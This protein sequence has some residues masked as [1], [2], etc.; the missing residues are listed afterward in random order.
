MSYPE[1][2][3]LCNTNGSPHSTSAPQSTEISPENTLLE[4]GPSPSRPPEEIPTGENHD[5]IESIRWSPLLQDDGN[6][7]R[8]PSPLFSLFTHERKQKLCWRCVWLQI[9]Q[10]PADVTTLRDNYVKDK[11]DR[12]LY[13]QHS[14]CVNRDKII[15]EEDKSDIIRLKNKFFKFKKRILNK[16]KG[17]S[18]ASKALATSSIA[19]V[20]AP[21]HIAE[22][23]LP[24]F[25]STQEIAVGSTYAVPQTP[26]YNT[27]NRLP[28]A[29][30]SQEIAVK[31]SEGLTQVDLKVQELKMMLQRGEID[32]ETYDKRVEPLLRFYRIFS[33]IKELTYRRGSINIDFIGV[34][35]LPG[36]NV[37]LEQM[38]WMRDAL[39][40]IAN[41][42]KDEIQPLETVDK[43]TVDRTR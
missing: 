35:K 28:A 16:K 34:L 37:S 31:T 11:L 43:V 39:L 25:S 30:G 21:W 19:S 29:S 38:K 6:E 20:Q 41:L 13:H 36:E 4:G 18:A 10:N 8:I 42:K 14:H 5:E 32:Q 1:L 15:K 33:D 23:P 2:P 9:N 3:D 17:K 40:D 12:V 7:L 22:T 26:S 27:E 24:T